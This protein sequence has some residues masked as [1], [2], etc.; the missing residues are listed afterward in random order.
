MFYSIVKLMTHEKNPGFSNLAANYAGGKI[1]IMSFTHCAV[2][3]S[4][5]HEDDQTDDENEHSRADHVCPQRTKSAS[6]RSAAFMP[7]FSRYK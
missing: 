6:S 3:A 1:A 7:F 4:G 5:I 2:N